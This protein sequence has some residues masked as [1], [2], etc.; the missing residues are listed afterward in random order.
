MHPSPFTT[1]ALVF[2]IILGALAP[3]LGIIF[4]AAAVGIQVRHTATRNAVSHDAYYKAQAAR[5]KQ[6]TA[7]YRSFL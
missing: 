1:C 3:P 2:A 6:T 7:A 4:F 5:D